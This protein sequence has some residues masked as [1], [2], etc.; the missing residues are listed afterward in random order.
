MPEIGARRTSSIKDSPELMYV[1]EHVLP[2]FVAQS[3]DESRPKV[4]SWVD[5]TMPHTISREHALGI[6]ASTGT[7]ELSV[8]DLSCV[9]LASTIGQAALRETTVSGQTI[10]RRTGV[11]PNHVYL[12]SRDVP[13]DKGVPT[14]TYSFGPEG[15]LQAAKT[16]SVVH[17]THTNP[18]IAADLAAATNRT[19][20]GEKLKVT[21]FGY[22]QTLVKNKVAVG[23]G[24]AIKTLP[25]KARSTPPDVHR[26]IKESADFFNQRLSLTVLLGDTS[27]L[28]IVS[29]L[30]ELLVKDVTTSVDCVV[31]NN[32]SSIPYRDLLGL[33]D[34]WADPGKVDARVSALVGFFIT[35]AL[36]NK[37]LTTQ[38]D[39]CDTVIGAT[40][41]RMRAS[42]E[43]HKIGTQAIN[44][45]NKQKMDM[46]IEARA[47][48]IIWRRR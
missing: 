20:V 6:N 23:L 42:Q 37:N 43:H 18:T 3:F 12:G 29:G 5:T 40:Q 48:S 45:A 1:H 19:F 16:R 24:D 34:T 44:K 17:K 10:F 22:V 36:G 8:I 35:S 11:I 41:R 28:G 9:P 47:I 15:Q 25:L 26:P 13:H 21:N 33:L 14:I 27:E 32:P 39:L 38:D 46:M 30:D 7:I 2:T 31:G 4:D